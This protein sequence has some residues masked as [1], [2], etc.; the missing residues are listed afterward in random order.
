M[1]PCRTAGTRARPRGTLVH[2]CRQKQRRAN[3]ADAERYRSAL[4]IWRL[5]VVV[6]LNDRRSLTSRASLLDL[7]SE[8]SGIRAGDT[9]PTANPSAAIAL[10]ARDELDVR[11]HAD[12]ATMLACMLRQ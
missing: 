11:D 9:Y 5:S 4:G 7:Q 2:A 6:T 10:D 12:S 1:G 3:P 8:L